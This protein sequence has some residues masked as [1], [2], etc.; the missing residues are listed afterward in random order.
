VTL[1]IRKERIKNFLGDLPLIPEVY[2]QL[3]QPGKPV[4]AKFALERLQTTIPLW[5][6]QAVAGMRQVPAPKKVLVFGTLR[7]WVEHTTALSLALAGMGHHVRLAF[8]PY[9]V[10][11]QPL[12]RFDLRRQNIY[13]QNVL[14][15]AEPLVEITS[16]LTG[17]ARWTGFPKAL[18]MV[19]QD[20][21]YKDTQY[22]LQREQV[23][24]GSDLYALRIKRN[25]LAA[26]A[27]WNDLQNFPPDIVIIPNGTILEF[28]VLYHVARWLKIPVVTYE[29]G[30]Q[31]GR[32]W[33]AHNAEVM[34]QDT[35]S[36]WV[37][38]QNDQLTEE[39]FMQVRELFAARQRASLWEN[40]TRRW[41]G[42]PGE[43][44]EQVRRILNLDHR[45]I[46]LLATNVIGDSLTL[47]RQV[48]S[49]SMTEWLQRTVE[50]FACR[51]DIQF[52]IRIHP[53]ELITKGPSVAEVV[54]QALKECGNSL[55]SV[56]HIHLV[57]ADASVNTYDLIE[58]ADV[59][60]VYTTTVG[61]EM[62]MSGIPCIVVG[63]T[64]Y[65]SRGFTLDPTTWE[66]YFELLS[67]VLYQ[68]LRYR[69]TE[70]QVKQAWHYAYRFFFD[71]P[72]PFPWHL[73]HFWDDIQEN[74]LERVLSDEG[75]EKYGATFNCLLGGA[76]PWM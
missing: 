64:H 55:Q 37:N 20:V 65:R 74:P 61:L 25:R 48:F 43:G 54:N 1:K 41:Q 21:S 8:L 47:G 27:A 33:L 63:N 50:F 57:S 56:E 49:D 59:G 73:V 16:Y 76:F 70:D 2:W 26:S 30:E 68:P 31:R 62:A 58:I 32:I 23:D 39:Q 69:L 4:T 75:Q 38:R 44:G 36:L 29:F 17:S 24:L 51:P 66:S 67:R 5:K 46:V 34:R 18:D 45:P 52:V 12:N 28:G 3:R 60:L 19:V 40:F 71:Y 35:T 7:Y 72:F 13:A 14:S 11:Q 10:W 6:E 15:Q 42:A 53:G 22:T 9:A